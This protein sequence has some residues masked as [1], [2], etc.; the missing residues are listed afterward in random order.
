[1]SPDEYLNF[2]R[3]NGKPL[4]S[5]FASVTK[6]YNTI[7]VLD[8]IDAI[9]DPKEIQDFFK[10]YNYLIEKSNFLRELVKSKKATKLHAKILADSLT[11]IDL[12]HNY[13]INANNSCAVNPQIPNYSNKLI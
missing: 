8:D 12:L 5:D 9:N 2:Y 7:K 11:I 3:N 4:K 10:L 6:I 13:M 1:M